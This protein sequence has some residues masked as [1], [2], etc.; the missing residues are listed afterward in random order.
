MAQ[1]R[2]VLLIVFAILQIVFAVGGC[3]C[4]GPA[5]VLSGGLDFL[6][7]IQERLP[8]QPQQIDQA[9]MWERVGRQ[10]PWFEPFMYGGSLISLVL[11]VLMIVGA[12]GML[13]LRPWGWHATFAW[14]L[15]SCVHGTL[16]VVL[17]FAIINPVMSETQSDMLA[18]LPPPPP[19]RLDM[20]KFQEQA[21]W[22]GQ[23]MG[24]A[25][26]VS[27]MLYPYI[28]LG[29]LCLPSMR[30]AFRAEPPPAT[31]PAPTPTIA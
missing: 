12:V 22:A 18:Q 1:K 21:M 3:C 23:L 26:G 14:A 8:K 29:I 4:G 24:V 9:E 13:R 5:L 11:C 20:R 15:A 2:P 25:T 27:G 10:I 7:H 19:G 17:M 30:R 31:D 28:M 16:G 6:F